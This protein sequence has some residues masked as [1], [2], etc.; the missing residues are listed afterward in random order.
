LLADL[1]IFGLLILEEQAPNELSIGSDG[2]R[3]GRW[4]VYSIRYLTILI[5]M[6][7]VWLSTW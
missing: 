1:G 4:P 5:R 3:R 2:G 7:P 6:V